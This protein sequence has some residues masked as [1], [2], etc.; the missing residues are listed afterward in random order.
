ML[1]FSLLF[2]PSVSGYIKKMVD[3]F[4]SQNIQVE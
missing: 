2:D 3:Q 4:G 1:I